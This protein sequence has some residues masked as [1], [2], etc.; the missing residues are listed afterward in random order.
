MRRTDNLAKRKGDD[1]LIV[2]FSVDLF[3][4]S[5]PSCS[6]AVYT[7]VIF[8]RVAELLEIKPDLKTEMPF[9]FLLFLP[10]MPHI[11]HLPHLKQRLHAVKL[12]GKMTLRVNCSMSSAMLVLS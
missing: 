3:L 2:N 5:S 6:K 4:A 11:I 12:Q 10:P 8:D 7:E 9:S 1:Q